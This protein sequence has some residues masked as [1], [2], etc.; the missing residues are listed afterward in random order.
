MPA[1]VTG[2]L[3]GGGVPA[4]RRALV[5]GA[6]GREWGD[7]GPLSPCQ[8]PSCQNQGPREGSAVPPGAWVPGS[9]RTG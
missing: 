6:S 1:G 8:L 9:E 7:T 2:T 3:M 5:R 4:G